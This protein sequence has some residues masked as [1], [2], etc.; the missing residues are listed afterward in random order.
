MRGVAGVITKTCGVSRRF[1]FFVV[2]ISPSPVSAVVCTGAAGRAARAG[3]GE[4]ASATGVFNGIIGV[5][6]C[7]WGASRSSSAEEH[8]WG[9]V[10]KAATSLAGL[11]W[12]CEQVQAR[13]WDKTKQGSPHAR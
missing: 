2:Y 6:E 5:V 3:A 10:S 7:E 9:G 13:G 11:R 12:D 8:R 1:R 4:G